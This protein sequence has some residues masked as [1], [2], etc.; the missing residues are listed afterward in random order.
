VNLC[1]IILSGKPLPCDG[2]EL[3][4][5]NHEKIT[6]GEIKIIQR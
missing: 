4:V 1:A 3:P 6:H 2:S 5:K